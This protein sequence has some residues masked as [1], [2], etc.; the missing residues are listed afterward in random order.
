MSDRGYVHTCVLLCL[1]VVESVYACGLCG[2]W[3]WCVQ[4]A[5]ALFFR[6]LRT[7]RNEC[8]KSTTVHY[9]CV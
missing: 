4:D 5:R 7:P 3:A 8:V 1:L 9:S 6:F 2:G